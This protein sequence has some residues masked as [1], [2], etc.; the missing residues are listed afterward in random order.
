MKPK[1]NIQE[2]YPRIVNP[3]KAGSPVA[4]SDKKKLINDR[5]LSSA[6][7]FLRAW[8]SKR[9]VIKIINWDEYLELICKQEN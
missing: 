3:R 9:A 2:V 6:V 1:L 7:T 8:V 5:L 4:Y